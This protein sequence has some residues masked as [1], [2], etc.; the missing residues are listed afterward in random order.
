MNRNSHSQGSGDETHRARKRFGQNFL[1][2]SG[3]I[4]RIVRAI[5]A[6]PDDVLVEIGPGLGALTGPLLKTAG[7]LQVVEIDRDLAPRLREQ[8][9]DYPGFVVHQ[10]DALK[11]DFAA[12]APQKGKLRLVGNLPYNISTPLLFH[13]LGYG[14]VIGDMHFMLQKEVV[15]RIV[16]APG[17]EAYGRLSVTVAARAE[18]WSLFTVGPG[19]FRPAPKVDSAIVRILPRKP[20]FTIADHAMFDRIV[21]A[22]F[23]H[24][25]KQLSNGLRGLLDIAQISAAGIDPQIRP[26]QLSAEAFARLANAAISVESE[27]GR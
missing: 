1:H 3:V 21:T 15:D 19:A 2:D 20:A 7:K 5:D 14:E 18:A 9:V 24:R 26:E 4:A 13:L 16:A 12:L 8:F 25:R 17:S 10:A 11:F 23:S 6:Q 27:Q 22:A